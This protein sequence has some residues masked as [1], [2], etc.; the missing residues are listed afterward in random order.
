MTNDTQCVEMQKC[1][2]M[3]NQAT[4]WWN[5]QRIKAHFVDDPLKLMNQCRGADFIKDP[6]NPNSG[7]ISSFC[8]N[9]DQQSKQRNLS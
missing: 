3:R 9:K 7:D 1:K 8:R 5:Y 6:E 2:Y 4:L